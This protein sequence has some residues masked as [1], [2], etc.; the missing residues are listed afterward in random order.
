MGAAGL[1]KDLSSPANLCT[2]MG[3][4]PFSF[5]LSH[6]PWQ[7]GKWGSLVASRPQAETHPVSR[8]YAHAGVFARIVL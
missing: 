4:K 7:A 1:T 3:I 2:V 5:D 8:E 6:S